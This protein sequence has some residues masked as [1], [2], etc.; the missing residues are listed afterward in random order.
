M[1]CAAL[2]FRG[3]WGFQVASH[4]CERSLDTRAAAAFSP[5]HA[6]EHESIR[7]RSLITLRFTRWPE[8]ALLAALS[9]SRVGLPFP[10][11]T[12]FPGSTLTAS[13]YI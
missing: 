6:R 5:E 12:V 11:G 10:N 2:F 1:P 3:F 9:E 7:L 8:G 13:L 4:V